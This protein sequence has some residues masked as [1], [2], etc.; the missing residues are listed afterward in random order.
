MVALIGDNDAAPKLRNHRVVFELGMQ[1][2]MNQLCKRVVYFLDPQTII[3]RYPP[4]RLRRYAGIHEIFQV[5]LVRCHLSMDVPVQGRTI[6]RFAVIY[7][8]LTIGDDLLFPY[9]LDTQLKCFHQQVTKDLVIADEILL[10]L[11]A[12]AVS[13]KQEFFICGKTIA[14]F[15]YYDVATPHR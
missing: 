9:A 10:P 13:L 7:L 5:T 3:F 15:G 12:K 2:W 8:L 11:L 6:Y 4:G 14:V 1:V